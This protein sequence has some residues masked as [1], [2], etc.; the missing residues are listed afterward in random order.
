VAQ[1]IFSSRTER[2][3]LLAT[4]WF[5][6]AMYAVRPWPWILVAL[7]S[8]V[9]YPELEDPAT[10]YVRTIV[11]L[12]PSPIKGLLLASF[13]AAY[14]S[15]ISTQLNWGAS[16]LVNDLYLRFMDPEASERRRV[17]VSRLATVL[18][19]LL[20]AI[21]TMNLSSIEGAWRI[22][23]AL[24]AGTGLVYILRWYWWRINAWS[25]ISA[26][27]ASLVISTILQA[28][29][30]LDAGN[31]EQFAYLML[32]TVASTTVVWL[33]VTYLTR[34]V[35]EETLLAFYHRVR[36]GGAGWRRVSEAAGYGVAPIPGG[37][38]SWTNWLAGVVAVY[39]TLFGVGRI[40]FG[41][42]LDGLLFLA[43]AVG[44]F[45]WIARSLRHEPSVVVRSAAEPS[46]SSVR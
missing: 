20:S 19:F 21:V 24:G 23:L 45:A 2:D 29:W 37:A 14:M 12:L 30:R 46:I 1:R 33:T 35:P 5:N 26:M 22:L 38:L 32:I 16:Y 40:L 36:P 9:L 6:V 13:A 11:D 28:G 15:T 44:A 18:L 8:L 41:Q 27:A 42:T 17:M 31:P 4:L 39:T 10:G 34:P 43:V 3:G 25:E 7:A